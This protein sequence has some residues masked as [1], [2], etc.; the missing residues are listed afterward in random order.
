MEYLKNL[1]VQ[2][3]KFWGETTRS[4]QVG[5]VMTLIFSIVLIIGVGY[6]S[7]QP[8]YV[9]LTDE[10]SAD[11]LV[12]IMDELDK[13]GILY[14][15]SAGGG[16]IEVEQGRL[17]EARAI[18][19]KYGVTSS[20]ES[21]FP[22]ITDSPDTR[23]ALML[24]QQ[25][26]R[27]SAAISNIQGIKSASVELTIGKDRLIKAL[28]RPSK[29]SVMLTLQRGAMLSQE[30]VDAISKFVAYVDG[31][32]PENISIVDDSGKHYAASNSTARHINDKVAYRT[33][34]ETDL[35]SKI[36]GHLTRLVGPGNF[37]VSVNATV[38]FIDRVTQ[39]VKYD[40]EPIEIYSK[41]TT[42]KGSTSGRPNGGVAG[43]SSNTATD[44]SN[45]TGGSKSG[46]LDRDERET[47][48]VVDRLETKENQI[49]ND[50]KK[51]AVAV[52]VQEPVDENGDPTVTVDQAKL[53]ALIQA[54]IGFDSVRDVLTVEVGKLVSNPLMD[55]LLGVTGDAPATNN[56][57]ILELIRN[58][59]LGLGALFAFVI[60]FLMLKKIKPMT[61]TEP[62]PQ[63]SA[64]RSRYISDLV[65]VAKENP[66]FLGNVIAGWMNETP[67]EGASD[68]PD[69][70]NAE[71][72]SQERA[73]A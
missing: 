6:W 19:F 60:A 27:I 2:F 15:I 8:N 38:D 28:N 65:R 31:L 49:V 47:Q 53:E 14:E 18:S 66:R 59:S 35:Q 1:G 50:I 51:L 44:V 63:I 25:A 22:G 73:A 34:V 24:R 41:S 17:P 68:R 11:D 40:Q 69:E 61:I 10:V 46:G 39:G 32:K 71:A 42:E 4:A 37:T 16:R 7:S 3:K 57:F 29:A 33:S 26:D 48:K 30:Q 55:D 23:R 13:K 5:M 21:S 67:L 9:I 62:E 52:R 12:K 58:S 64:E 72:A 54:I 56:E 36:E 43:T 70:D 45:R 20:S